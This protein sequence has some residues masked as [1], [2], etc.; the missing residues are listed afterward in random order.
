MRAM[1]WSTALAVSTAGAC[2]TA[3][4]FNLLGAASLALTA[5]DFAAGFF[6]FFSEGF[7]VFLPTGFFGFLSAG[8]F[9]FLA[10]FFSFLAAV[11][12]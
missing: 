2:S 7:F 9:G 3:D 8:F 6:G 1:T 12:Y 4:F 5:V 10:V 11:S